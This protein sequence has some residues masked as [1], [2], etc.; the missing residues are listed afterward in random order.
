MAIKHAQSTAH[1]FMIEP[2]NFY[3][4]PE[5]LAT[6]EHQNRDMCDV[7]YVQKKAQQE[8]QNFRELLESKK[9]KISWVS[10]R[11]QS[12]DDLFCN[13]WVSTHADG[14]YSLYPMLAQNRRIERRADIISRFEK[15]YALKKD[16][17]PAEEH[18]EFLESTGSLVLDRVNKIAYAVRSP[19]TSEKLVRK[20][21]EVHRY[22]LVLFDC[23]SPTG[24]PEYHTN[25]VMFIGSQVAALCVEAIPEEQRSAVVEKISKTHELV[26][27][28]YDQ[29]KKFC[30]NALEVRS[31]DSKSYLVMS[32][33][34]YENYTLE[35]KKKFRMYYEE[36]LFSDLST[37]ETFGGG[38][39]RCLLLELF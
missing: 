20:W 17:S 2:A 29:V 12:P 14:T 5:T 31:T 11:K 22:E 21:A 32:K 37:I 28:S 13:N 15:V 23:I 38:S 1:L 4:N 19:R 3:A 6:N 25:V 16:F 18:G 9:I 10:G 33:A 34:A 36:L 8:H 27:I 35:Q 24:V 7:A 30:G 26:S 39:A